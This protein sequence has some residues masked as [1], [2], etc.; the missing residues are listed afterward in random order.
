MFATAQ[1]EAIKGVKFCRKFMKAVACELAESETRK[2]LDKHRN[3][4]AYISVDV[5][6]VWHRYVGICL[7]IRGL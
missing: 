2:M 4:L 5:G 3:N 1:P 7:H 6:T